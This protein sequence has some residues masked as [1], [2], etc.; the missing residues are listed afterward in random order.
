MIEQFVDGIIGRLEGVK[1]AYT[2]TRIRSR[3]ARNVSRDIRPA[4][5]VY[6]DPSFVA[7][8]TTW[9]RGTGWTE[10]QYFLSLC[11][12]R[13]LDLACGPCSV[14][15]ELRGLPQCELHGCDI[16]LYLLKA[17]V[18][19]GISPS[20]LTVCDATRTPYRDAAF[21]HAFSIGSLA[22]FT[23]DGILRFVAENR[24]V[25]SGVSFHQVPTSRDGRDHGWL[26]LD[27]SYFLNSVGWWRQKFASSYPRVHV[28]DSRWNDSI[29]LGKWFI[30]DP[31]VE[32][33]Q[34]GRFMADSAW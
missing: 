13:V 6:S 29:S 20:R 16:S 19:S 4:L 34:E 24:R 2:R 25:A 7:T 10:I 12:G 1:H 26:V 8:V 15:A 32:A 9:G 31:G 28:V 11:R 23:E 5:D 14:H 3:L 27:Q 21:D 17:A 30:C 22:H 18:A 33:R